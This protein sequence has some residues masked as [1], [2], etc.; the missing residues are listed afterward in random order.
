MS[1]SIK[2]ACGNSPRAAGAFA[3]PPPLESSFHC[4]GVSLSAF[5]EQRYQHR[6]VP[7]QITHRKRN[8]HTNQCPTDV[9]SQSKCRQLSIERLSP[10]LNSLSAQITRHPLLEPEAAW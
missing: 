10:G 6:M 8:P 4:E 5:V 9:L 3:V 1:H 2:A 7:A